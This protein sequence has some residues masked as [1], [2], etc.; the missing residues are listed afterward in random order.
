VAA[1][2]KGAIMNKHRFNI[3]PE[4][5]AVDFDALKN[6]IKNNGYDKSLPIY[7]YEDEI[8]DGWNRQK[9]CNE[10]GIM[11]TYIQFV[12]SAMEAI[13]FCM[14]TNK[15][16]NLNSSQWACIAVEAD[17]I[18]ATIGKSVEEEKLKK[19][20]ENAANQFTRSEPLD[21]KLSQGKPLAHKND[22]TQKVAEIFNTNRTYVN[23]AAKLKATDPAKFEQIR[24]GEKTLT[25]VKKE[26]KVEQ[27]KADIQAQREAI[28]TGTV[29][30]PE[31]VFEVVAIDP[32]WNYG[33]EYDPDGSRVANPYPEMSQQQ[34]L[35]LAPPFA[36]DSVCF[37][38]TTHAFI[39]DAK[40]LLDKW[41][42][43]YKATMVWDKDK[44][45]MGAWLRMQCE[46][47]LIGIKGKPVWDNTT[48]RDIIREPR[49]EHSRKPEA[50][51]QLVEQVAVGRRLDYF[52]REKRAGWESYGNDADKFQGD[53]F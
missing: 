44:I 45:G 18:I 8:L 48:W 5:Q 7:L 21:N 27:R 22:T 13:E 24:S 47:C 37:L 29:Q 53:E 26:A 41:G 15:R 14:R 20:Q 46:F 30:M 6:D 39:F 52:S 33:R 50:F 43:T 16:R 28:A 10:L 34:L 19:Q 2:V 1:R 25:E 32:P 35:E 38:W 17:G 36:T 49:R 31:G 11:P 4:M 9:A 12:G 23:D 3:F 40:E 42:F 51:Y